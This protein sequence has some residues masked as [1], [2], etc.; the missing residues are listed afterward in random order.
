MDRTT[1]WNEATNEGA[2]QPEAEA[3]GDPGQAG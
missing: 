1:E 3:A 2:R